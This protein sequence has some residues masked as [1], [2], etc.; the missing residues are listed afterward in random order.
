MQAKQLSLLL[1]VGL[2][3]LLSSTRSLAAAALFLLGAAFLTNPVKNPD[4]RERAW[5]VLSRARNQALDAATDRSLSRGS[6]LRALKTAVLDGAVRLLAGRRVC[7]DLLFFSVAFF[8]TASDVDKALCAVGAFGD[9][10]VVVSPALRD[11]AAHRARL[12]SGPE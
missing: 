12:A 2:L 8:D 6:F 9:W 1:A 3:Y 7:V 5:A 4:E 10:R 11:F